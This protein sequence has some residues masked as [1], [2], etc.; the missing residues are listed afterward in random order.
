MDHGSS[1]KMKRVGL[2]ELRRVVVEEKK[3][4]LLGFDVGIKY[5]GISVSDQTCRIAIP[6]RYFIF[7]FFFFL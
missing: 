7:L 4:R 6:L 3:K 2:A 1:E 5:L